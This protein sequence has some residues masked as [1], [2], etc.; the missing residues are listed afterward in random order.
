MNANEINPVSTVIDEKC[1]LVSASED[2]FKFGK[3]QP[4]F[5]LQYNLQHHSIR[6]CTRPA[7]NTQKIFHLLLYQFL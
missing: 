7:E 1:L 5:D 6:H 4:S 2:V 3:L